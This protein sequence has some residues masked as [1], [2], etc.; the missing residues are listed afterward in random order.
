MFTSCVINFKNVI[1]CELKT[2]AHKQMKDPL[3]NFYSNFLS[4]K[5]P[6][7]KAD[8]EVRHINILSLEETLVI[9]FT[10]LILYIRKARL[11]SNLRNWSV[12]VMIIRTWLDHLPT[13][14]L[15]CK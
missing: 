14:V 9:N 6:F 8:R 10:F 5:I 4:F 7:P 3:N 11:S 13:D 2:P 1:I 12:W 15:K